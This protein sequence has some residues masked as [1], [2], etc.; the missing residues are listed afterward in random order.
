MAITIIRKEG[1]ADRQ[2]RVY[3]RVQRSQPFN[4]PMEGVTRSVDEACDIEYHRHGEQ[5]GP[6]LVRGDVPEMKQAHEDQMLRLAA[7]SGN[8]VDPDRLYRQWQEGER[9]RSR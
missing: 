1:R 7:V 4:M 8:P 6:L 2:R 3:E 9:E 5:E